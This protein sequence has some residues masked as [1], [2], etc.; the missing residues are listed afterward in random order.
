MKFVPPVFAL[1]LVIAFTAAN[2]ATAADWPQWQ[3]P[4]R[5]GKSVETGLLKEWP[6]GGPALKWR[7][8]EI[9]GGYSAPAVFEGRVYGMSSRGED[10]VVW[11][12]NE[13]DGTEVWASRIGPAIRDGLPQGAEGAGCTPTIDGDRIYAI[14]L[15]GEVACL[16]LA[17]GEVVWSRNFVSDFGGLLPMWR[18]NESPLVDGNKVICTPGGPE[19]LMVALDKTSGETL[20]TTVPPAAEPAAPSEGDGEQ[21]GRRRRRG[22]RGPRS[23]AG[24]SSPIAIDFDGKRQYVQFTAQALIGVD[25]ETGEQLWQYKR[26]ANSMGINCSTP[27]YSDGRVFAASAYGAGGGMAKLS[28][29]EDGAIA[30]EE[31]YFTNKMQNHHGGMIVSDGVLYG[32]NGGNGGG[33]LRAIDFETGDDLWTVREAPK[34]ALSMADGMLYLYTENGEMILVE[35]NREEYIERGRFAHPDR[36]ESPAWTHPVIA[37]GK[38]YVRDQGILFCYD[39]KGAE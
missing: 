22:G 18:Y 4:A 39:V 26:P 29:S 38:L 9:G 31:V 27:I 28:T 16:N 6:E 25:A 14:G 35:P 30:A 34:G 33:F 10:E 13:A 12:L 23:A 20:W 36:S 5:D 8:D 11:C 21:E 2:D 1:L 3:G 24:Y 15:G 19:A 17:D 7:A 37:N 32:T